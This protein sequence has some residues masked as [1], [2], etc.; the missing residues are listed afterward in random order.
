MLRSDVFYSPQAYRA[1]VKSPVEYVVGA[2]KA[3]GLQ[4]SAGGVIAGNGPRGGGVLAEMGQIPLEPP[5][6][7]GW[8]GGASWLNSAT[9]FARLNLINSLTSGQPLTPGRRQTQPQPISTTGDLGTAAQAVDYYLPF[10]LDNNVPDAARQV[11]YDYAGG[12][13]TKIAPDKLRGLVY[14]LLASPQF[15]LA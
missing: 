2:V 12:A 14:I 5:N 9:M 8:P 1:V 10:L 15:H 4:G 6:V 7:A 3:L 11:L 13:D